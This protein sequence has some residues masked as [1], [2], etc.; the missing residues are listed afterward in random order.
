MDDNY[1]VQGVAKGLKDSLGDYLQAQYHIRDD[2]L[3]AERRALFALPGFIAQRPHIEATPSYA[4]GQAITSL[5]IPAAAKELLKFCADRN[6]GVPAEPY[7]HQAKALEAFL[8]RGEDVL[9][10]TGTGSGKTEIFLLNILGQLAQEAATRRKVSC[11]LP[12]CRALLL[13]R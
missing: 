4:I 8:G 9:A 11:E 5:E 13:Y 10:A 2:G 1:S 12:G 3:V 6:I 7:V